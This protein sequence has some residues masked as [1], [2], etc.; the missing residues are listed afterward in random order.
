MSA[1]VEHAV[2]LKGKGQAS[3]CDIWAI[4]RIAGGLLSLTVEA[5]AEEPF[6]DDS[7][8]GWLANGTMED[9]TLNRQKRWDHI[10]ENLPERP[11]G[12]YDPIRYQLLHRCAAAVIEA[13]R[14]DFKHAAFI[15]QAFKSPAKSFQDYKDFCAVLNL[16]G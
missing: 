14:W 16:P 6:G 12:S 4:V 5:K 1:A 13:K 11:K 2:A 9:P 3:H 7:L 10:R 15:V 8:E